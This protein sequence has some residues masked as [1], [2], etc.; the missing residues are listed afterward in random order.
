MSLDSRPLFWTCL[1][2]VACL[3]TGQ[4]LHADDKP[5]NPAIPEGYKEVHLK[6]GGTVLV[7]KEANSYQHVRSSD[8]TEAYKPD[9]INYGATSH[10]ADK[11]FTPAASSYSKHDSALGTGDQSSFL[12]KAYVDPA[13]SNHALPNLNQKYNLPDANTMGHPVSDFNKSYATPSASLGHNSSDAYA[14]RTSSDQ[15]RTAILGQEKTAAFASSMANKPFTGKNADVVLNRASPI[16]A[17]QIQVKDLPD[18]PLTIDEV[19]ALINHGFKPNTDAKPDEDQPS[20]ALNDP[21]YTPEPFRELQPPPTEDDKNDPV[22]PPGTMAQP[23]PENSEP[24]PQH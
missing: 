16:D 18:R 8:P 12:T 1:I 13:Q 10:M 22:P 14:T 15:R 20:K 7:P 2:A 6:A 9:H 17:S 11:T 3:T 24:L 4:I 23:P 5:T 19:R 21:D